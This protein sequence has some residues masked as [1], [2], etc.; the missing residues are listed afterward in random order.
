MVVT[1]LIYSRSWQTTESSIRNI[2]VCSQCQVAWV[3]LSKNIIRL[4]K[5]KYSRT[6]SIFCTYYVLVFGRIVIQPGVFVVLLLQ[7]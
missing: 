2:D 4:A 7:Q 5:M 6:R 3:L 1:L